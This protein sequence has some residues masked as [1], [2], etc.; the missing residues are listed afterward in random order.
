MDHRP[1]CWSRRGFLT[2]LAA[3]GAATLA[4]P[5]RGRGSDAAKTKL[6][7]DNLSVR[8]FEWK[9]P[10]LIEY[11]ASLNVDTL[12]LSDLD[13]YDSL[14]E[15]YLREIGAQAERA[16]IELQV[17]TG[18]ICPTSKS[19]DAQKWGR[20]EDHARLLIRTAH[21]LGSSVARFYLGCRRAR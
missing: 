4:A 17:G 12:L 18:S 7:F 8:A 1:E 15:D 9:A 11:A 3:F 13:V 20:A 5:T 19:Y 2:S 6:G 16:A 10:Q 21:R 14:E